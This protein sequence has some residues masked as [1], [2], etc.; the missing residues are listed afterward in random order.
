MKGQN[1]QRTKENQ[2]MVLRVQR[3]KLSL[4]PTNS[5]HVN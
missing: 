5:F 1:N 2:D 4:H 3:E